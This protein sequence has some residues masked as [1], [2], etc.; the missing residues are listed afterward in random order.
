MGNINDTV[1]DKIQNVILA[2]L[3][4]IITPLIEFAIRSINAS[5]GR[6]ASR[7]M[8]SS[9]RGE[10]IGITASLENVPERNKTLHV[11]TTIDET[12]NIIPDKVSE[13]SLPDTNFDRKS[14]SPH[15]SESVLNNVRECLTSVVFCNPLQNIFSECL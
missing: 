11:L 1:E 7:V 4:S 5:S 6:D 9:E 13:L 10:H 14:Q 12:R 3:N 2:A 8:T 15:S